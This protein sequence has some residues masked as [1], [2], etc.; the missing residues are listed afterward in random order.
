M[1]TKPP[2]VFQTHERILVAVAHWQKHAVAGPRKGFL[3]SV[4]APVQLKSN[5]VGFSQH[6]HAPSFLKMLLFCFCC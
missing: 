2:A 6:H 5:C 1:A 4:L 3:F